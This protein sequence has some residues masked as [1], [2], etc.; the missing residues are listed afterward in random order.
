MSPPLKQPPMGVW[1]TAACSQ[2]CVSNVGGTGDEHD[3]EEPEIERVV[4]VAVMWEPGT[5]SC[6]R[7]L[8]WAPDTLGRQKKVA[9]AIRQTPPGR[10][11]TRPGTRGCRVCLIAR[12]SRFPGC[13]EVL[14][15]V[16]T[17]RQGRRS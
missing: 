17:S 9:Q 5:R 4:L 14:A 6:W 1:K 11:S 3:P 10:R 7:I 2:V 15:G 12:K 8:G 13:A 16:A